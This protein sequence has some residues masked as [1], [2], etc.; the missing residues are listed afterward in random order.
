M[1]EYVSL[2]CDLGKKNALYKINDILTC[3]VNILDKFLTS[4][5]L[6]FYCFEEAIKITTCE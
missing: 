5:L 1:T 6:R 4:V 3:N 2:Y